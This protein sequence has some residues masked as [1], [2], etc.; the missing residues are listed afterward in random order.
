MKGWNFK[1]PQY[2]IAAIY[3]NRIRGFWPR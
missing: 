2:I 1:S 3:P